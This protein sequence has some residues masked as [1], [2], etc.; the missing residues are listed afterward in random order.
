M[1]YCFPANFP[2]LF[3]SLPEFVTLIILTQPDPWEAKVLSTSTNIK[4]FCENSTL[5]KLFGTL[6]SFKGHKTTVK[7]HISFLNNPQKIQNIKDLILQPFRVIS[8]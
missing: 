6:D 4:K 8:H 7:N 5:L 2:D 1:K 3:F